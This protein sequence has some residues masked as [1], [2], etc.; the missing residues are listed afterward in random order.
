MRGTLKELLNEKNVKVREDFIYATLTDEDIIND[1]R[2]G[3][4]KGCLI[5]T[6]NQFIHHFRSSSIFVLKYGSH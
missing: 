2:I 1:A 3:E 6:V 5:I 4:S